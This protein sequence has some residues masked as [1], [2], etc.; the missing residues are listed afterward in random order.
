LN[1]TYSYK[2]KIYANELALQ[3]V[4]NVTYR[5]KL[6]C[7]ATHIVCYN[8]RTWQHEAKKSKLLLFQ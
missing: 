6:F 8:P 1:N 7:I 4:S 2:L 5:E 3:M